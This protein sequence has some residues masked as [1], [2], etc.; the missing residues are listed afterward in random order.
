VVKAG[1]DVVWLLLHIL[2]TL[3]PGVVVHI[4]DVFWP[5]GYPDEWLRQHRDWT[6]AYLIHA[7]LSG[8]S[9]W[10]MQFFSSWFWRCHPERVPDRLSQENPGSIWLQ[11]VR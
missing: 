5:F 1:S 3:A 8:N 10:Q 4:H 6:E 11:R 7:F 2:P 9:S